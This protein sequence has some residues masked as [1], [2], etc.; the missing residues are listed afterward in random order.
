MALGD[1]FTR[2][3]NPDGEHERYAGSGFQVI[4]DGQKLNAPA[5]VYRGGMSIP[6]AWRAANLIA[7]LLGSVPWESYKMPP[8]K[9]PELESPTPLILE[10]PS[11]PETRM[12]TFSAAAL[13][14]IWNGNAIG[15]VASRDH[16]GYPTAFVPVPADWV[17]VRRKN[18][19]DFSPFPHGP[20]VYDIGGTE[21]DSHDIIHIKGPH[22]PGDLR[23]MGVLE[24]HMS[25]LDLSHKLA[26]QA[27]AIDSAGVP[28]GYLSTTSPDATLEQMQANKR[29]WIESQRTRTVA[30]LNSSTTYTP[31][32][33]NPEELELV[34]AR[35]FS[36]VE[37]ALIFGL[38]LSFVGA[39][40]ASKTYTNVEQEGLN[41]LRYTLSGHLARFEQ[42]LSLKR[43]RRTQVK[44]DLSVILRADTL[45]RYQGYEIGVK[46]GFLTRD[47]VRTAEDRK[48]LT[49]AQ[50]KEMTEQ[51]EALTPKPPAAP[52]PAKP[53]GS[54]DGGQ[55]S[56][57]VNGKQPEGGP[58][59]NGKVVAAPRR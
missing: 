49:P 9:P 31:I 46:N 41:L 42:T 15:V 59:R 14:L 7:D 30:A 22:R 37:I 10:Q 36:L 33:W 18:W 57:G 1:L 52:A 16:D 45:L 21:Y 11:P 54:D 56:T 50:L 25:T 47:E 12:D 32:A 38:P 44:A 17:G 35:K 58:Q 3:G 19:S 53:E 24:A 2:G 13:D 20:A 8:G 29:A 55:Q 51:A 27:G 48:P 40:Q 6:G 34:E 28:T 23:G 39:D 4:I 5:S 26:Q 43:P